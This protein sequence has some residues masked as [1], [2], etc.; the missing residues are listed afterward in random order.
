[1]QTRKKSQIIQIAY[2]NVC[3]MYVNIF[4]FVKKISITELVYDRCGSAENLVKQPPHLPPFPQTRHAVTG[5]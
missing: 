4:L 1:M 3:V 2:E 5:C